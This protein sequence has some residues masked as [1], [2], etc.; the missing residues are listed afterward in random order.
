MK[1]VSS[2]IFVLLYL[3]AMAKPVFPLFEYLFYEDYITEFLC[4][5]KD[6]IELNCNGKCYLMERLAEENEDKKENLPKIA[7]EEY[8][9]GFVELADLPK[10]IQISNLQKTQNLY[11]N[12]YL[13]L[14]SKGVFHPPNITC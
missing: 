3:L 13:F 1:I 10:T 4:I 6:R 7:M 2:Y 5:N 8:P 12:N 11:I 9:I 14:F